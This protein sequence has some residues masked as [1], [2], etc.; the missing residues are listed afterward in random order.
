MTRAV[1]LSLVLCAPALAQDRAVSPAEAAK[2]VDQAVTLEMK[3]ESAGKS[4][5][6]AIVFLNSKSDFRSDD[7]F[8][9]MVGRKAVE[10][11]KKDKVDDV[12]AHFKGKTVRVRGKVSLFQKKPQIVVNDA[13]QIKVVETK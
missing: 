4:R 7:N 1:A 2:M 12:A 8:T 3:V 9:V 11:F 10:G 13:S 5:D 6:G